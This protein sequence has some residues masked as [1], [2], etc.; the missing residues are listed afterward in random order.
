MSSHPNWTE[1]LPRLEFDLLSRANNPRAAVD[2]EAW[3]T[4]TQ[5]LSS[6]ARVLTFSFSGLQTADVQDLVQNVLLKLQSL[7]TMRRLHAAR[8]VEG[9]LF[10]M[11][12]NAAND[13]VRRRQIERVIFRSLEDTV[14]EEQVVEHASVQTA[15]NASVLG[16]ALESLHAEERKLLEMRFWRNMSIADIARETEATYSN[17][18]VRLFRILYKLRVQLKK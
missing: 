15:E 16:D 11:L 1:L 2:E 6:R 10:V 3:D 14:P 9:Y 5:F 7:E 13:L 12:R 17:T 4:I 18:A 8:S